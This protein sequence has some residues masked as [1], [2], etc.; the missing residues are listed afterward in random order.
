MKFELTKLCK[1][2][3]FR[4]DSLKGWL[5]RKRAEEISFAILEQQGTFPCHKTVDYNNE[6]DEDGDGVVHQDSQHCAGAM[7]MLE[8][9]Q[10]PNQMMR[11]AERLGMYDFRKLVMDSPVFGSSRKFIQHHTKIKN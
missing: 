9:M 8:K 7:I 11:I 10:R 6:H 2:C 1:N 4:T 5:G 3:P